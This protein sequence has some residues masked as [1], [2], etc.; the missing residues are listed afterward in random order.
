MDTD[1]HQ[2]TS[3]YGQTQFKERFGVYDPASDQKLIPAEWQSGISNSALVGQLAGLVV[4]SVCQDRYGCRRT[5]MVFMVWMAVAIFV[6]VFA[7]SL[8]VLAFGE[9]F[10]GIP[11]G[12]FQVNICDEHKRFLSDFSYRRCQPHMLP[13]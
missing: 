12:V 13:K 8:S 4:N 3:F 1:W 7:P 5:M 11:W 2:I 10:C 9:A 6:P